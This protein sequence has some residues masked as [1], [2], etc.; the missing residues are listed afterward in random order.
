MDHTAKGDEAG[1]LEEV[2]HHGCHGWNVLHTAVLH[3]AVFHVEI[4]FGHKEVASEWA[5]VDQRALGDGHLGRFHQEMLHTGHHGHHHR[6][7]H[8]QL[9]HV[10]VEGIGSRLLV[11]MPDMDD[12]ER[13]LEVEWREREKGVR[14]G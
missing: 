2:L 6:A 13:R 9:T 4:S 11:G 8:V 5:V 12:V 7:A 1:L 3:L 14:L 10:V